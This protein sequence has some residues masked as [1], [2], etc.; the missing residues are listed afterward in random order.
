MMQRIVA[1]AEESILL[2]GW[3]GETFVA[4]LAEMLRYEAADRISHLA[5]PDGVATPDK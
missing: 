5:S 3:A 2:A 4:F 1:N